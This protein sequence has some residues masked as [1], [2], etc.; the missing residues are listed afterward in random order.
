M[1]TPEQ[2]S[3]PPKSVVQQIL[4]QWPLASVLVGV[5]VGLVIAVPIGHWGVGC[6][7]IGAAVTAGGLLRLMPQQRVGLLAVRSRLI[8]T[9]LLLGS[10]VGILVLAWVIPPSR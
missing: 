1:T 2:N 3:R 6:T 9:I 10:G 8:D 7:L 5:F 4:G